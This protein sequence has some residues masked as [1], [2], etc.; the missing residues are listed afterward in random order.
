M[1]RYGHSGKKPVSVRLFSKDTE[2]IF[3]HSNEIRKTQI[4]LITKTLIGEKLKI[5]FQDEKN[6]VCTFNRQNSDI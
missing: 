6:R 4:L 5:S 3:N 2:G 1:P